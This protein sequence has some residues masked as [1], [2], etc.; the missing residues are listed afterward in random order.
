MGRKRKADASAQN[1]KKARQQGD[2]S[3]AGK[4]AEKSFSCV[5]ES[6]EV[7]ALDSDSADSVIEYE[8]EG[9]KKQ[10]ELAPSTGIK[11]SARLEEDA[12]E[13]ETADDVRAQ[14]EMQKPS[15]AS[16]KITESFTHRRS[17]RIQ[18]IE[19][20][21][22]LHSTIN[23][24]TDSS[25][26]EGVGEAQDDVEGKAIKVT[27]KRSLKPK[28][29]VPQQQQLQELPASYSAV[30]LD[31][32]EAA[33]K[34]KE[35]LRLFNTYYLRFVQEEEARCRKE[36]TKENA[37]A[38]KKDT[39]KEENDEPRKSRRP[40]LKGI[41][42]M[43][44]D[45]KMLYNG[46]TLGHVPGIHVGDHFFSRCEMMA[47]GL[48]CHWLAGIDFIGA[49]Y[50]K[51]MPKWRLP[52]ASSIVLSGLYEDDVDNSNEVVYT[53][54]GGN[55]L[56]GNKRQ[57]ADQVMDKGNL[58][59]KNSMEQDLPV[60][61]IR[62]HK[63]KKSYTGKVYTYDG[64]YKVKHFWAEKG[65][66]G[67]TVFKFSLHRMEEQPVLTT[68]Q[69][70]FVSGQV[71]SNPSELKGLVCADISNGLEKIPV[72]ASNVFDKTPT[73]P[74]FRYVAR[75]EVWK[76][77]PKP[78]PAKGCSCK[79]EC[80]DVSKCSCAAL[81]GKKFPYVSKNGG[82]LVEPMDVVYECG[83]HCGCGPNCSNRVTQRGM[84]Y[85]LEVFKTPQ[86][87]WAVRS[88]DTI[89]AG[90][91]VCEY[92]G[93]LMKTKD[94][95]NIADNEYFFELD[96]LQTIKSVGARQRRHMSK[97]NECD[98]YD[99]LNNVTDQAEYCIDAGTCGNVSRFIN[100]SCEPNLFVQCV[101]NEHHDLSQPRIWFYASDTIHP[102]EE[103][104]YDYGYELD[105]VVKDGK[106]KVL[107][108]FCGAHGC[109]E[110]LH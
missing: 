29:S 44:S 103:L 82:R 16:D 63:T 99:A 69:V 87:G 28:V 48:H 65:I 38:K 64:L 100:H 17:A 22:E 54:Q 60:R 10:Q 53:G 32:H 98:A 34:V 24:R 83:P 56:L 42:Q 84:H 36:D 47:I 67:F 4:G 94:A 41:S 46:K 90:A 109:R 43:K 27:K 110:R 57:I 62:G 85:R 45:E 39:K 72:P 88:W 73:A 33:K 8:A 89:P 75:N 35:T 76:G 31:D 93:I 15:E 50:K 108:C 95:D 20:V 58:A 97:D 66:S 104:S 12:K 78:L 105:S 37:T 71:P 3:L 68:E 19:E 70:S 77:V 25:E 92:T 81:N 7:I 11:L 26:G 102:L 40:D 23:A 79:G 13:G 21:K 91:P 80:Y 52:V 74:D 6:R 107:P 59:L 5:R 96:C 86:K 61:L 18:K 1:P 51:I 2:I 9:Q 30:Q 101:L 14:D 49:A 55:D 106:V